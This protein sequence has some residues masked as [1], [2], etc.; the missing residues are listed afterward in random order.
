MQLTVAGSGKLTLS[1]VR[2]DIKQ[3]GSSR[4]TIFPARQIHFFQIYISFKM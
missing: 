2:A 3:S 4:K 1:S